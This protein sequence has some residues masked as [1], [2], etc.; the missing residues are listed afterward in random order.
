M[1]TQPTPVETKAVY[2]EPAIQAH[3]RRV[4]AT[5]V[6]VA[7]KL[8]WKGEQQ[9]A[10]R[11]AADSHHIFANRVEPLLP[12]LLE[13]IWGYAAQEP[14]A[15][16]PPGEEMAKL[17]E[18][19]CFFVERWEFLPYEVARFEQMI[20]ELRSMARDGFFESA[21]VEGL[22]QVPRASLEEV[23]T[24]VSKLPVFPAAALKAMQLAQNP[25]ASAVQ[26]E[27][28]VG[29][30]PVLAGEVLRVANSPLYASTM[31]YRSIR[32]AVVAMGIPECCRVLSAA[33][34]RPMFQS[35][36]IR[37][38]WS[39]SM[40]VARIAES[41][42]RQTRKVEPEE[43]FLTGLM[44]D[45]GRLALWKLPSRLTAQ[46]TA[47]LDHGCEP[48]FAEVLLCGFDHCSAGREVMRHWGL[49]D[50]LGEAVE[51]HHQPERS[52]SVLAQVLY[53]ADH[54]SGSQEDL[55]SMARFRHAR[56]SLG[57]TSEQL[58]AVSSP[59]PLC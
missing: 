34:F 32:Q 33:A 19:S 48:M 36:L 6:E 40:E 59:P 16:T 53:L 41:L 18:M 49:P 52:D 58:R 26:L 39:H 46:Y 51:Y 23:K 4:G 1:R 21:H 57:L 27:Q 3:C 45:I 13:H 7:R 30:D 43:A 44:H 54:C 17:L 10:L 2:D 56:E 28:I 22:A 42:A 8:G 9:R 25:M 31:P 29:T 14:P 47:L 15:G 37:P 50:R 20:E 12:S 5:A 11:A 38:L 24:V 35:P 55:P